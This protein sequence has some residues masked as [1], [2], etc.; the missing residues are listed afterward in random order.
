M[1]RSRKTFKGVS[2]QISA[3]A[4]AG[5]ISFGS[6]GL[7]SVYATDIDA[8]NTSSGTTPAYLSI[9]NEVAQELGM[10]LTVS[11]PNEMNLIYD[12]NTSEFK[13]SAKVSAKGIL[14]VDEK[15]KIT[16]DTSVNYKNEDRESVTAA[17]TIQFGTNG[18]ET[19]TADQAYESLSTLDERDISATVPKTNIRY[20]GTYKAN[21]NFNIEVSQLDLYMYDSVYGE[22]TNVIVYG[23]D[24][25]HGADARYGYNYSHSYLEALGKDLEESS[26]YSEVKHLAAGKELSAAGKA[27]TLTI[28]ATID[29]KNVVGFSARNSLKAGRKMSD[30]VNDRLVLSEGITQI[31]GL[32]AMK[33]LKEVTIP[34]TVTML[35]FVNG[36]LN[37]PLEIPA[38]LETINYNGTQEQW[39]AL[40][41]TKPADYPNTITVHCTDGDKHSF[42]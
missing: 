35:G 8:T 38:T 1:N 42:D 28:P 3:L 7:G 27:L 31:Y 25:K 21:I 6:L 37:T 17:G 29:G 40:N 23:S 26:E 34:S 32:E 11:I 22:P 4:L 15:L 20:K 16:T 24:T 13:T 2:R 39:A 33:I 10:G 5:L 12:S 19:Y 9:T 18:V 41:F 36:S 14:G 30:Y